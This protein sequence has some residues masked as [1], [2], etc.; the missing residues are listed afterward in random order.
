MTATTIRRATGPLI[1]GL[2]ILA[3]AAQVAAKDDEDLDA[4]YNSGSV[5]SDWP[6]TTRWP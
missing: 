1:L 5:G 3:S 4:A 2:G 6:A